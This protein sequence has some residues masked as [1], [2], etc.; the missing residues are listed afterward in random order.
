MAGAGHRRHAGGSAGREGCQRGAR[1][2]GGGIPQGRLAGLEGWGLD[3]WM[4]GRVGSAW[5][6]G[7]QDGWVGRQGA[8]LDGWLDGWLVGLAT[9]S[10]PALLTQRARRPPPAARRSAA[11]SGWPP[12][13]RAPWTTR[14]PRCVLAGVLAGKGGEAGRGPAAA[15]AAGVGCAAAG[16]VPRPR[17]H[18]FPFLSNPPH[19]AARPLRATGDAGRRVQ[20]ADDDGWPV[21][22]HL[23]CVHQ[24]AAGAFSS[25]V[26]VPA[27]WEEALVPAAAAAAGDS[28]N[29][30][31]IRHSEG[32]QRCCCCRRLAG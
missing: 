26:C 18:P 21:W 12:T 20:A 25:R 22:L 5:L 1:Q 31:A 2:G 6:A 19:P 15:Q 7:R 3:V 24:G 13:S 10:R 16:L 30:G 11:P 32:R 29:T 8:W 4:G 27:W 23:L 28:T 14:P 17:Q 9:R